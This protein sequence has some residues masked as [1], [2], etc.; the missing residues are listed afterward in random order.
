[1]RLVSLSTTS[2]NP[3]R[4]TFSFVTLFIQERVSPAISS[5]AA[6]SGSVKSASEKTSW[7]KS[8]FQ[9]SVICA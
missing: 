9:L 1:M 2:M 7:L 8:S 3:S 6:S 5:S 4:P